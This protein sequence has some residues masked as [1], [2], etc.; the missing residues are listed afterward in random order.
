MGTSYPQGGE[1]A[2][3]ISMRRP[4]SP[5]SMLLAVIPQRKA[6]GGRWRFAVELFCEP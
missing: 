5:V 6:R 3:T 4:G 1:T 2:Y